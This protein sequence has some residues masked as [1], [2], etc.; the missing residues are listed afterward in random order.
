MAYSG[1]Y[2]IVFKDVIFERGY[3]FIKIHYKRT[4]AKV[5]NITV[6]K[7]EAS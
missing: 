3:Q 5:E 7:K 2:V 4:L 1:K 6:Y